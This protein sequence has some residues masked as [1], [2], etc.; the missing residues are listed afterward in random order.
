MEIGVRFTKSTCIYSI[1]HLRHAARLCQ[2][3]CSK[4]KI[5]AMWSVL[6]L[7]PWFCKEARQN[8]R[9]SF[10]QCSLCS[11]IVN[12][13]CIKIYLTMSVIF[14]DFWLIS[15]WFLGYN[16]RFQLQSEGG[17][18]DCMFALQ[19]MSF[20][21]L[22]TL[23]NHGRGVFGNCC[24]GCITNF[25]ILELSIMQTAVAQLVTGFFDFRS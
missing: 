24:H 1:L 2:G 18:L 23:Q 13:L 3:A 22:E 17:M 20:V 19:N 5:L 16:C 9:P 21:R 10:K 4:W 14:S 12:L 11:S 7:R 15:L 25:T 8:N 6:Y